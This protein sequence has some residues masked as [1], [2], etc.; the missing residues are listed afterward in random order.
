MRELAYAH[1]S[2]MF[3]QVTYAD[4]P[5]AELRE[6][7]KSASK[8]YREKQK[9]LMH[10]RNLQFEQIKDQNYRLAAENSLL[11]S[12]VNEKFRAISV[13][14]QQI[15]REIQLLS[16]GV[17]GDQE[18]LQRAQQETVQNTQ[19][20]QAQMLHEQ[21]LISQH[22]AQNPMPVPEH[23][24]SGP[25]FQSQE[26]DFDLL[27]QEDDTGTYTS[28]LSNHGFLFAFV[29]L[30]I[31]VLPS[32][33]FP[34]VGSTNVAG[35]PRMKAAARPRV[36]DVRS[37]RKE[38]NLEPLQMQRP[39]AGQDENALKLAAGFEEFD[40]NK[41]CQATCKGLVE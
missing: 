25:V 13:Q 18:A 22:P 9:M 39:A 16:A 41:F 15:L 17:R 5:L 40:I 1:S 37:I 8:Q 29:L 3:P 27:D 28:D 2:S 19:F 26:P 23:V 10:E 21:A 38:M 20:I 31:F 24:P 6:K 34:Q 7:Q 30:I 14:M 32:F 4:N 12:D 35:V 11:K 33:F 36:L